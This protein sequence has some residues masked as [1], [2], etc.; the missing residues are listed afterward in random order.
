MLI[1]IIALRS[2]V[3]VW[4]QRQRERD[5]LARMTLRELADIGLTDAE[6]E[7]EV[8]APFWRA[9]FARYRRATSSAKNRRARSRQAMSRLSQM[10]ERKLEAKAAKSL[11]HV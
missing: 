7:V 9:V 8:D 3:C 4:L 5:L 11:E 10:A 1:T 6:R 2:L